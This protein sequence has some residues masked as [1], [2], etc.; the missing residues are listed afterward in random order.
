MPS[1]HDFLPYEL[2]DIVEK[3]AT[4]SDELYELHPGRPDYRT[5]T[6]KGQFLAVI[7]VI[8]ILTS[9]GSVELIEV[10]IGNNPPDTSWLTPDDDDCAFVPLQALPHLAVRLA[11]TRVL[12]GLDVGSQGCVHQVCE[13]ADVFWSLDDFEVL[14]CELVQRHSSFTNIEESDVVGSYD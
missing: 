1:T 2:P 5:V 14:C 7:T 6:T 11:L 12:A 13:G 3:F 9:D 4:G 8:G 10:A